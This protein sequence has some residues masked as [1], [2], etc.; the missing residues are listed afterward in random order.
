[1][2]GQWT[3][4]ALCSNEDAWQRINSSTWPH[5]MGGRIPELCWR[6]W[7]RILCEVPRYDF[8]TTTAPERR[9]NSVNFAHSGSVV[10]VDFTIY[11]TRL[12]TNTGN[13]KSYSPISNLFECREFPIHVPDDV[14][15]MTNLDDRSL[16]YEVNPGYAE[17]MKENKLPLMIICIIAFIC[18]CWVAVGFGKS[19]RIITT[20]LNNLDLVY[21][22]QEVFDYIYKNKKLFRRRIRDGRYL[23]RS[24][25][26]WCKVRFRDDETDEHGTLTCKWSN[27]FE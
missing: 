10:N 22:V 19:I 17:G 2:Q 15:L 9:E 12:N 8:A 26:K 7:L 25:V 6:S 16:D 13:V 5:P 3:I 24:N 21:T 4:L 1:M 23:L 18:C 14:L 27:N 20:I 11:D